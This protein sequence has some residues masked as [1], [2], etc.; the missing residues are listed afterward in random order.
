MDNGNLNRTLQQCDENETAAAR[1]SSQSPRRHLS[2]ND[3]LPPSSSAPITPTCTRPSTVSNHSVP[4]PTDEER[5]E[6]WTVSGDKSRL[7]WPPVLHDTDD[8]LRFVVRSRDGHCPR[9][10]STDLIFGV[11]WVLHIRATSSSRSSCR[12]VP[13][14]TKEFVLVHFMH[15]WLHDYCSSVFLR[16]L[17]RLLNEV[18]RLRPLLKTKVVSRF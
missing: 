1:S 2:A 3:N 18:D 9:R 17:S 14:T 15:L 4:M 5:G 6:R 11:H 7:Q 13:S 16:R 12:R 10:S 8:V